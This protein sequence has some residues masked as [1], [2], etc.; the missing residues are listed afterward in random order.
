MRLMPTNVASV[1]NNAASGDLN[2]TI[3]SKPAGRA[4]RAESLDVAI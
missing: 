3:I 4:N 1:V 2:N